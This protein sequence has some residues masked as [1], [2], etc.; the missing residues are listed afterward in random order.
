[1][2]SLRL[3]AP[4]TTS[5]CRLAGPG[6]EHGRSGTAESHGRV[7]PAV[8]VPPSAPGRGKELWG[9]SGGS[10]GVEAGDGAE[11]ILQHRHEMFFR[12]VQSCDT[13]ARI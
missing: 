5:R 8:G 7:Q 1:M 10:G 9:G 11:R 13:E 12:T 3:L 6:E 2:P 4:D